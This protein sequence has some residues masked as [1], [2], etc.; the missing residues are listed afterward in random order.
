MAIAWMR[1][2]TVA[3][4]LDAADKLLVNRGLDNVTMPDVAKQANVSWR[5]VYVHFDGR[6]SVIISL[7]ARRQAKCTE[8][9]RKSIA[10]Q[11]S[12]ATCL[13]RIFG[14]IAKWCRVRANR[15]LLVEA[16]AAQSRGA[17][18]HEYALLDGQQ[19]LVDLLAELIRN[20]QSRSEI[21]SD[22][23]AAVLAQVAFGN[24]TSIAM[25]QQS[26]G[27]KNGV[28]RLTDN[29]VTVFFEGAK[30]KKAK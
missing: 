8:S 18:A 21:R 3:K 29:L 13:K 7:C 25:S 27:K 9:L 20:A 1:E 16:Q 14:D 4:V 24:L 10:R 12:P 23:D 6:D 26:A 30:R 19:T 28:N 22:V 2:R 15:E 5:T 11:K 17:A